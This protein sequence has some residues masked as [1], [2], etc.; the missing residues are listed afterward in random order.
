MPFRGSQLG[1]RSQLGVLLFEFIE[2][3]VDK[4]VHSCAALFHSSE[5][6]HYLNNFVFPFP[7]KLF[8]NSLLAFIVKL[9][10]LLYQSFKWS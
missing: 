6:L 1:R 3:L 4:I 5:L 8:D 2:N 9:S 10:K 7:L